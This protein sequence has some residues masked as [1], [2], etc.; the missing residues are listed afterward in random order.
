MHGRSFSAM[1]NSRRKT[2]NGGD[3]SVLCIGEVLFDCFPDYDRLG[4]APGNVAAMLAMLGNHASVVAAVGEDRNGDR[5]VR[6]LE[7][8]GVDTALVQRSARPTGTVTVKLDTAGMATYTFAEDPA[9]DHLQ[10]TTELRARCVDADALYFGT[11][12]GRAPESAA[13]IRDLVAGAAP[14]VLRVLDVNLRDPWYTP[15]IIRWCV[16]HADVIK[17]SDE[18]VAP[19]ADAVGVAAEKLIPTL[20]GRGVRLVALT[21]GSAGSRLH[22]ADR[23]VTTPAVPP[24]KVAD[25]VGAGDSFTATLIDGLLRGDELETIGKRANAIASFVCS[26][27]GATPSLPEALLRKN[28]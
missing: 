25:T 13:T 2:G 27:P 4:G 20:L 11:L 6:E 28:C 3:K 9:W 1:D 8:L 26:Q 19:V 17:L 24:T 18:E 14:E 23:T 15:E 16:A 21:L 7:A 12:A 10:A 22:L 5:A